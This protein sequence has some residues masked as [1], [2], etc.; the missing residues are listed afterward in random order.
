MLSKMMRAL[1]VGAI[2]LFGLSLWTSQ[3]V[4]SDEMSEYPH[5]EYEDA[6]EMCHGGESWLPVEISP[7]FDHDEHGFELQA[8]H[9]RAKCSACHGSLDFSLAEPICAS[10]HLDVH[11]NEL[12]TDCGRCHTPR[13]FIDRS[14]M[15]REHLLTRFPLNGMHRTLDCEDCHSLDSSG[16]HQ[17]V[18]TPTECSSCHL[19]NYLATTDPNHAANN[20]PLE[21][22]ACHSVRS[23]FPAGFNHNSLPPGAQC[24]DCHLENYQATANPNHQATG[25]PLQCEACHSTRSWVPAAINHS[26]LPPS[27]ECRDCHL[28]DYQGTS[29][30][31]HQAAGFP[32]QCEVCHS[33]RGWEPASYDDHDVQYFPIFSGKHNGEWNTCNECHTSPNNFV[34]YSCIDCHEHDDSGDLADEH[35]EV[36]GYQ[37]NSQACFSCHRDGD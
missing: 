37:Y 18:N 27:F 14:K 25:I 11:R 16:T 7:E 23:W 6:C 32:L 13:S 15:T 1:L 8:N 19:D 24:Q 28:S 34:A 10:C 9:A 3:P 20:I 4:S 35:S 22:E 26:A 12:G 5:G 36:Q 21:C 33:T 2:G 31:D 29:D 30:P 17:F